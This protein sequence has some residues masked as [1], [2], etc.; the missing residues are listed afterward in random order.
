MGKDEGETIK[1]VDRRRFLLDDDGEVV[2]HEP[3]EKIVKVSAKGFRELREDEDEDEDEPRRED[4]SIIPPEDQAKP[5][6]WQRIKRK[7]T[8]RSES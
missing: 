5:S 8:G 1:I 6:L 2:E 3:E 4:E 7:F